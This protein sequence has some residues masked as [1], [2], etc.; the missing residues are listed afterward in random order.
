MSGWHDTRATWGVSRTSA[1]PCSLVESR[2][3]RPDLA[4]RGILRSLLFPA[5]EKLTRTR[6]W[7]YYKE[8]L[9]FDTW[10]E[11]RRQALSR[12]RLTAILNHALGSRL[13]QERLEKAGIEMA[14]I[15]ACAAGAV[16]AQLSPVTKL[17]LRRNFPTGATIQSQGA[18][19]R[20]LSTAGTTDRLSVVADF[21]K[22]D[23]CR[24][25]ELRALRMA[26]DEDV[27][28]KTI[29][30]PPNACNVVCALSDNAP[31]TFWGYLWTA[32][33]EGKLFSNQSR[34]GLR[35][36]FERRVI[37][38]LHAL[39][40]IPP[41][42]PAQLGLILDDYLSQI[43][44]LRPAHLRAFPL[45][46]MW[47]ADRLRDRGSPCHGLAM[48]SP[49]GGLTSTEMAARIRSGLAAPFCDKYGTSELGTVAVSCGQ[50]RGMH[51]FED[52]FII[53]LLNKGR[54]V[55]AGQ[56]GRLVITDLVN[57]AMP[58]IRYDVG[59][60]GRFHAGPCPCGR[61]TPRLEVLGRVQEVLETSSGMLTSSEVADTF[62]ADPAIAN[63]RLDE[64]A[65]GTF[66][67]AIVP[68]PARHEPRVDE[69][70]ERF[71]VLHG[72]ACK[73]RARVVPFVR[74]ESSGKYKFIC[75][76]R[77]AEEVL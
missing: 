27:R 58:L 75:R 26:L 46:L 65:A 60:V 69:W 21:S 16:L 19:W 25:G 72:A 55:P 77:P 64:T 51:I 15:N 45:Y 32:L 33:R 53:E 73:I 29:E 38:R 31:Q 62:F 36:R 6:F 13:H 24:S 59:D 57:A 76:A 12:Q 40:P 68:N 61:R 8:S 4:V 47:L 71:S 3:R 5:M 20:F 1:R 17:E 50:G 35:G 41:V 52:L 48:T 14:P 70:R 67:A 22:R 23:H 10:D 56:V 49:Y 30:I 74:P 28:V 66:E 63:F 44:Y 39:P 2:K 9:R 34:T 42:S 18:D 7:S 11:P 54:P 43:R 37:L